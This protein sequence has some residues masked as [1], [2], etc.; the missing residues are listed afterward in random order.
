LTT[1]LRPLITQ[2]PYHHLLDFLISSAIC[3]SMQGSESL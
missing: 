3:D 2:L 1:V